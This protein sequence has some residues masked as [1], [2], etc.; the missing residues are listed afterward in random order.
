VQQDTEK[1]TPRQEEL[2]QEGWEKKFTAAEPKLSEYIRMYEEMG[3]EVHEEPLTREELG[4]E[5]S[6]CF[7]FAADIFQTIYTRPRTGK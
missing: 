5:C 4:Q 6:S 2:A 7:V 3:F 1:L